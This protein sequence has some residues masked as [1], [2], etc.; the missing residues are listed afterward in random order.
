MYHLTVASVLVVLEVLTS[1]QGTCIP[2]ELSSFN[3]LSLSLSSL[4]LKIENGEPTPTVIMESYDS[5]QH[6]NFLFE[7]RFYSCSDRNQDL[8]TIRSQPINNQRYYLANTGS[9]SVPDLVAD[10]GTPFTSGSDQR[11]FVYTRGQS[12]DLLEIESRNGFLSSDTLSVVYLP[13]SFTWVFLA[14]H[15]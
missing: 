8:F 9:D 15:H 1:A 2:E 12:L 5:A 6:S 11:L 3:F 4:H 13:N 14:I 10:D 7:L